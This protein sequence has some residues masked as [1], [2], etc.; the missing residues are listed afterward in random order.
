[1]GARKQ[2]RGFQCGMYRVNMANNEADD[3]AFDEQI[4]ECLHTEK[5]ASN[6][7]SFWVKINLDTE[8]KRKRYGPSIRNATENSNGWTLVHKSDFPG[9][10][11]VLCCYD[12]QIIIGMITT[13]KVNS[14]KGKR[15]KLR[16]GLSLYQNKY[17]HIDDD[18]QPWSLVHFRPKTKIGNVQHRWARRKTI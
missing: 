7:K 9:E 8:S 13:V 14:C 6:Q 16:S 3:A 18:G 12:L 4:V 10:H 15:K 1:M 5:D 2:N 11:N 17:M